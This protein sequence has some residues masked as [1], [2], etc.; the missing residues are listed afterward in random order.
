[1]N[2]LGIDYGRKKI[3]LAIAEGKLAEPYLVIRVNSFEGAV[4]KVKQVIQVLQVNKVIVG[5][6]EGQMAEESKKFAEEIGAETFDET[7]TT[8]EAQ[9]LSIEAGVPQ[10]K[11]HRLEDAFAACVMLQSY[12]DNHV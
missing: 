1:M 11:R 10:A 5:V 7:L 3:G 12:L 9:K 2:I 4:A 8:H 6:S